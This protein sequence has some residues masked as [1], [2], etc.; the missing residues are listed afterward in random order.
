M[1]TIH[2]VTS[3]LVCT[4]QPAQEDMHTCGKEF[5]IYYRYWYKR[6]GKTIYDTKRFKIIL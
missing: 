1:R 3:L 6:L 4:I 5:Y 2:I